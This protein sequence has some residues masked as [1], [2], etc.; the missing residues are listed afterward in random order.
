[1][2]C[3][4]CET[5]CRGDYCCRSCRL[6]EAYEN[7][8]F[9]RKRPLA[10]LR[11]ETSA[12]PIWTEALRTALMQAYALSHRVAPHAGCV[13]LVL[14]TAAC[15]KTV[16]T[17]TPQT[18]GGPIAA[19]GVTPYDFVSPFVCTISVSEL[20]CMASMD[21]RFRRGQAETQIMRGHQFRFNT[22]KGSQGTGTVWFGCAGVNECSG[23]FM[24][25]S[26]AVSVV[27]VE[28]ARY[29]NG[30]D[31]LLV[32]HG[33]LGILEV[34]IQNNQFSQIRNRW[35]GSIAP[36]LLKAGPG[37]TV[38]CTDLACTISEIK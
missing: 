14:L 12:Y 1:M 33:S 31:P 6:A 26:P 35:S 19:V 17:P 29:W 34:D 16:K 36:P 7:V 9:S 4:R 11:A 28:P 2:I 20:V 23:Y 22:P 32:P 30:G 8:R 27:P 38:S 24:F 5:P 21:V 18:S 13:L 37:H 3:R 15:Q 25:G 10:R